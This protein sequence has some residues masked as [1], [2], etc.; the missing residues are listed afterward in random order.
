MFKKIKSHIKIRCGILLLKRNISP[1]S[2][3]P[4]QICWKKIILDSFFWKNRFFELKKKKE[5]LHSNCSSAGLCKPSDEYGSISPLKSLIDNNGGP[6]QLT[7]SLL[8]RQEYASVCHHI[9]RRRV[10]HTLVHAIEK[11]VP[12][13]E[14]PL[15]YNLKGWESDAFVIQRARGK[16]FIQKIK[17][18]W[19]PVVERNQKFDLSGSALP[20]NNYP[21]MI[22]WLSR[23]SFN[24]PWI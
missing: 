4:Y 12:K 3:H 14:R 8:E 18:K 23:S 7:R 16:R 13:N 24:W 21:L 9:N 11:Y 2:P 5:R 20:L 6:F 22:W 15:F 10:K 19:V 1:L 17:K